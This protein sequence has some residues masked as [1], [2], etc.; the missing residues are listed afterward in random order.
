MKNQ[1]YNIARSDN[2]VEE[3]DLSYLLKFFFRNKVFFSVVT[4]ISTAIGLIYSYIEKPIYKGSFEIVTSEKKGSSTL[5]N[6]SLLLNLNLEQDS[7]NKTQ[8]FI[9]Q[10][11][12]VL[13]PVFNFAKT[14]Y[15]KRGEK[16]E[17]LSYKGWLKDTLKIDFE[18]G[19]DVLKIEFKDSDK[20]L[21]IKVLNLISEKY[22][23]YSRNIK[24]EAFL[25][26]KIYLTKQ[27]DELYSKSKK[28]LKESN[29]F[30]INNGLGDIDGFVN[31]D[32]QSSLQ[33]SSFTG[34]FE[35]EERLFNQLN[36]NSRKEKAGQRFNKQF[37]TLELYESE[38]VILSSKLKPNSKVLQILSNKIDTLKVALKR[39]NE[40]L[41]KFKELKRIA[42]RDE[43][44]LD[45]VEKNLLTTK[46]ENAK[47]ND[48]WELI[49]LPTI[50]DGRVSPSKSIS[51]LFSF[52]IA[53]TLSSIFLYI[54]ERRSGIIY[55]FEDLRDKIISNFLDNLYLNTKDITTKLIQG[56][57]QKRMAID[58]KNIEN[59]RF[60]LL[61]FSNNFSS[62][63]NPDEIKLTNTA[64][65][66]YKKI[67]FNSKYDLEETDNLIFLVSLGEI[68]KKEIIIINNYTKIYG[69]KVLGWFNFE[70]K[71]IF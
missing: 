34:E 44:F 58:N 45:R 35:L 70:P 66:V 59:E 47:Q 29:K 65:F 33:D 54:K 25:K 9:L 36:I 69:D 30:A 19:T 10:S 38:Y 12:S 49:S 11:P 2:N 8:K 40:I 7:N 3:I 37:K 28:S 26:R 71:T 39:P 4:I 42:E 31:I 13:K 53:F 14:N 41:I 5:N 32:S 46:L 55:E 43:A 61:D 23:N 52:T 64:Q 63:F 17:N 62:S 60:I 24:V 20:T 6:E 16:K 67:K 56:V 1:E 21:I 48:P 18:R 51:I 27:R 22:Q 15:I 68:T 57:I 50:N